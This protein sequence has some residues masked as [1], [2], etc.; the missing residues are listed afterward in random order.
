MFTCSKDNYI[1]LYNTYCFNN[2]CD[3][4]FN[5]YIIR[6]VDGILGFSS[7]V[8]YGELLYIECILVN[9]GCLF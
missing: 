1:I 7:G 5:E 3:D 4:Y 2:I 8:F 6:V 9:A